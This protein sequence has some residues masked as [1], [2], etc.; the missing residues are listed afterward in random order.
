[1]LGCVR[2]REKLKV[3]DK[4]SDQ[5]DAAAAYPEP[6]RPATGSPGPVSCASL[7][8]RW[9]EAAMVTVSL[10]ARRQG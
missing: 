8:A 5:P 1:M 4:T 6:T 9:T 7:T 2:A 3:G 10:V